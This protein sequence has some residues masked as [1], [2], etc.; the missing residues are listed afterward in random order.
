MWYPRVRQALTI[1]LQNEKWLE[2]KFDAKIM[3]ESFEEEHIHVDANKSG[4]KD[5]VLEQT[6]IK[7]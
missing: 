2:K 5:H 3:N 6:L 4:T 1:C 7:A